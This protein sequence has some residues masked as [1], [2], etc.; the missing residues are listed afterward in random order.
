MSDR[1]SCYGTM[2][3]DLDRLEYNA[4]RR[5]RAFAVLVTSQGIGVQSREVSVD[6]GAW[7]ACQRC[8]VFRSC[9]DLCMAVLALRESLARR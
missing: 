1:P 9:Y 5:G 3:P 4:P 8:A 2:F 6:E 7:E